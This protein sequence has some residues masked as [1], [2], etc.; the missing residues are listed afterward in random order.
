MTKPTNDNER[1]TPKSPL[2]IAIGALSGAIA[3][4]VL[5]IIAYASGNDSFGKG[6]VQGGAFGIAAMV[7]LLIL[8]RT[9]FAPAEARVVSGAADEREARL[10]TRAAAIG[11]IVMFIA[12]VVSTF[13]HSFGMEAE[14]GFA[15]IMFSGLISAL[16][17]FAI[18]VRRG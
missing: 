18:L 3:C 1:L 14:A 4:G 15:I 16:A 6:I 13:L 9:R 5:A 8:A 2:G 7:T 17:A 11:F 12:A 10:A